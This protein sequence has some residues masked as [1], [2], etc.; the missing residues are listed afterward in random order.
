MDDRVFFV[1]GDLVTIRQDIPNKP[2]ML[3]VKVEKQS[4]LL[5]EGT[6]LKGIRCVWFDS[7]GSVNEYVFN[8]K[9]LE[10]IK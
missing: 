4:S 9:D 8:T 1:P 3:V 10:T 6:Q 2:K 7:N 5:K